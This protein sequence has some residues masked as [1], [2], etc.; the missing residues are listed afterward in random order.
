VTGLISGFDP[1]GD[2]PDEGVI[3]VRVVDDGVLHEVASFVRSDCLLKFKQGFLRVAKCR[4]ADR[5][6]QMKVR[7]HPLGRNVFR[8]SMVLKQLSIQPFLQDKVTMIITTG[9]VDRPDS[10]GNL[11]PCIVKTNRNGEATQSKCKEP[12]GL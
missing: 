9:S 11:A 8:F 2:E 7:K 1:N 3:R 5:R 10:I 4:S 6:Q 12:T